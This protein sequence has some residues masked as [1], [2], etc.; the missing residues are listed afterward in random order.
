MSLGERLVVW[1]FFKRWETGLSSTGARPASGRRRASRI[2]PLLSGIFAAA[3]VPVA[4]GQDF[5]QTRLREGKDAYRAHR[6]LEAVDHLRIAAFG[7]LDRPPALCESLVYLSLSEEASGHHV[8]A[9]ATLRRLME[10]ERRLPSCGD[11]NLDPAARVEFESRF[12]IRLPVPAAPVATPTAVPRPILAPATPTSAAAPRSA[13]MGQSLGTTAEDVDTPVRIKKSVPPVY[14]RAA[15][16]ARI[17]GTVV[18]RVQVSETGRAMQVEVA[19]GV[20]PDLD[21]AA[22]TVMQYWTFDPARKNGQPVRTWTNVEIPF[23]P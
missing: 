17:G 13:R 7:F 3:L 5:S 10:L 23:P 11:A 2:V 15:R 21:D 12:H 18:L 1:R 20:R 14:P 8:E 16:E 9:Q 4:A 6:F 22:V 19:R